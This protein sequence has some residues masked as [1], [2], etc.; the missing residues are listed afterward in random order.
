MLLLR[1][2][3]AQRAPEL[4]DIPVVPFASPHCAATSG[5]VPLTLPTKLVP[6]SV[7]HRF[8]RSWFGDLTNGLKDGLVWP[9]GQ[10]A[11]S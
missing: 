6:E 8:C 7:A 5:V 10:R 2:L 11:A 1:L 9:P 3:G 4:G